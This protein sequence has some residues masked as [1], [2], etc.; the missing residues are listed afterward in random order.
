[1]SEIVKKFRER[2]AGRSPNPFS[3]G[4]KGGAATVSGYIPTD[5]VVEFLKAAIEN[6]TPM[7]GTDPRIKR[8]LPLAHPQ[9]PWLFL[10]SVD[11]AGIEFSEKADADPEGVLEAPPLHD[12]GVY[13]D[14]E[15]NLKFS[16][17]PYSVATDSQIPVT[18]LTWYEDDGSTENTQYAK[19]WYRYVEW[20]P[21]PAAEYLTAETGQF[22]FDAPV[23][24]P[25]APGDSPPSAGKGQIRLLVP[26]RTYRLRWYRVPQSFL[27]SNNNRFDNAQGRV[28][29][30]AWEGFDPGTLLLQSV[31][32]ID[33]YTPP[34]PE[35][36]TYDGS[37]ALVS[38]EKLVDLEFVF[39]YR[40]PICAEVV[41]PTNASHIANGHNLVPRG[42]TRKWYYAKTAGNGEPIYPSYP[43]ELLFGNPDVA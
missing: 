16:T 38:Q 29:Q 34:F 6:A 32:P 5:D 39:L 4:V 2:K 27:L 7:G 36:V 3:I 23:T 37:T 30:F 31:S 19:E 8:T 26:S 33:T 35:F 20:L 11:G 28:N 13:V 9:Y 1:M 15:L 41:T 22:L 25:T 18:T 40:N 24:F 21:Q 14:H 12:Y 43:Y 17:R 10:D 42:I